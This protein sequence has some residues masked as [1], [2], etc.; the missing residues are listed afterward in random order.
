MKNWVEEVP[1]VIKSKKGR[2]KK[3]NKRLEH[4]QSKYPPIRQAVARRARQDSSA[5]KWASNRR[6]RERDAAEI[7]NRISSYIAVCVCVWHYHIRNLLYTTVRAA[8]ADTAEKL[9]RVTHILF[10]AAPAS[11]QFLSLVLIPTH[12]LYYIHVRQILTCDNAL[13]R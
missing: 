3:T 1:R 12:T 7:P 5:N 9:Y 10:A 13:S 2:E 4:T 6:E 11:P 8:I